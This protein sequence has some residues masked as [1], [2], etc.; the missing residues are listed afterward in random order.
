MTLGI[1]TKV[2]RDYSL[3][4]AIEIVHEYGYQEME[5]RVDDLLGADL[6]VEEIIRLT[7]AYGIGRSVHLLTEDL[8]LASLNEPIR[9][10]SVRQEME[11]LKLAAR[12]GARTATLHPGRKTAKTGKLE[13]AWN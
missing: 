3:G 8:N 7:D 13:E 2:L 6:S 9:Q 4:E 10:E 1:S 12:L 11:G 5:F